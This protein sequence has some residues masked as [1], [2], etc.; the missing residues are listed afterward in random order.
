[1]YINTT[2]YFRYSSFFLYITYQYRLP[3]FSSANCSPFSPNCQRTINTSD[4]CLIM[5][6]HLYIYIY[7]YLHTCL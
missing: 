3:F 1:M 4:N 2:S 6:Q 7:I 5:Q